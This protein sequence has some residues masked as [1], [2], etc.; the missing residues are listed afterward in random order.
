MFIEEL[1]EP[2]FLTEQKIVFFIATFSL[3]TECG[4]V[5]SLFH[6]STQVEGGI[7]PCWLLHNIDTSVTIHTSV[8]ILVLVKGPFF[9]LYLYG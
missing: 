7:E 3:E 5:P 8:D 6:S 9:Y 4:Y 2:S 1:Y